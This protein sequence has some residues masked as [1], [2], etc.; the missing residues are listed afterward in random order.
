MEDQEH[1]LRITS[2][3]C[4]NTPVLG[5]KHIHLHRDEQPLPDHPQVLVCPRPLIILLMKEHSQQ[6]REQEICTGR[7]LDLY[8]PFWVRNTNPFSPKSAGK[9]M[10]QCLGIFSVTHGVP[11]ELLWGPSQCRG[12]QDSAQP[13]K[14]LLQSFSN[15]TRMGWHPLARPEWKNSQEGE[16]SHNSLLVVLCSKHTH[17][18]PRTS[19]QCMDTE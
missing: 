2:A 5:Q 6:S 1:L 12:A 15:L 4:F 11:K 9:E 18:H 13:M 10:P 7:L 17:V 3:W 8:F 19:Q 14:V 16:R